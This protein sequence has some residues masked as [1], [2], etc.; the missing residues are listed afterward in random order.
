MLSLEGSAKADE[1][2][3]F[4]DKD[5]SREAYID[6]TW[7][8]LKVPGPKLEEGFSIVRLEK[9]IFSIFDCYINAV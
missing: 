5:L 4:Y 6:I 3:F 7:S 2:V 1:R 9:S 8:I